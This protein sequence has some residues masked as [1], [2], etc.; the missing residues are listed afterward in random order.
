MNVCI[1]PAKGKSRR[2]P[3]KNTMDFFGAPMIVRAIST[4]VES[5]LF[6]HIIVSTDDEQILEHAQRFDNVTA[7]MRDPDLCLDNTPV[8]HVI[9]DA[10][11]RIEGTEKNKI[12]YICCLYPC[13]PLLD[14]EDLINAYEIAV[15]NKA[16][17]C[18]SVCEYQVHPAYQLIRFGDGSFGCR[19]ESDEHIR[20]NASKKAY[21]DT[22][23]F[24]FCTHE[25]FKIDR[26]LMTDGP[27]LMYEL[28]LSKSVDIN[29]PE[30]LE[31]AK[32][33][34]KKRWIDGRLG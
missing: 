13:T 19:F 4:A 15:A 6:S 31:L 34:W 16:T 3:R 7:L 12:S 1:I 32:Y 22:G 14:C 2:L 33:Y 8:D 29:T 30:D 11:D 10:I 21:Y 27:V 18:V 23:G 25:A 5:G 9:E 28:P 20:Y 17:R 24:Y 26:Q